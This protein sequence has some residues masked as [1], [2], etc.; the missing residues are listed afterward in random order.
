M[1]RRRL[2]TA[3]EAL[4]R[5]RGGERDAGS[6]SWTR[7][8]TAG[9]TAPSCRRERSPGSPPTSPSDPHLRSGVVPSSGPAV[10]LR[11]AAEI[12]R[13]LERGGRARR[14]TLPRPGE[15]AELLAHVR[16]PL[17][18][19]QTEGRIRILSPYRLRATRAA[20]PVRRRARRRQLPGARRRRPAA[21]RRAP[22][23][24]RARPRAATPPR[25]SATSSTPASRARAS[26]LHL[27]YPAS[28][29]SGTPIPRS[30]FVDE[31]RGLLAP[32][33]T[34]DP[35][36]D[37]LEA[38]I[39]TRAGPED[40][41]PAPGDATTPRELARALAAL[42]G[43]AAESQP[44]PRA[45]RRGRP[46]GARRRSPRPATRC[47]AAARARPARHPDV[48]AALG[49]ASVPTAPRRSRSTT[50]APTAGSSATSSRPRPLG[51]DPEP[52]EDGGLVHEVLE[53]LYREPPTGE[54][55]P[56]PETTSSAGS[57]P[58]RELV[59]EVAAE[60]ALGPRQRATARI[61]IARFDAVLAR[62]LR[63]DAATGGPLRPDPELLEASFG[64]GARRRP[65]AGGARRLL[66]A[67]AD[68]PD[69]RRSSDGQALIRDYKLSSK[70]IAGKK[71]IEEGKLQ[72]PLYL[73]AARGFGLD[74]IGG[75]Y[76]PLGATREDR[77]RGLIDKDHKG[78]L[79][80][81]ETEHHYG[82]DFL[83][84]EEFDEILEAAEQR[85]GEIVAGMRAGAIARDPRG[86]ECPKLVRAGADLPDRARRADRGSRGRGGRGGVSE[87]RAAQP[88]RVRGR[89][90]GRRRAA[91]VPEPR[92]SPRARR[93]RIRRPPSRRR[94][95]TRATAT[96]SS[97]RAPAPARRAC[98]SRA[99]ATR[100]TST[101]SSPERILAFTFTERAAAEMR[102]R[103][104]VELARRAGRAATTPSG[105]PRLHRRRAGRRGR[106]RSRRSTAS[107]GACSPPIPIAAG[108][109]PRF[110]VLDAEE[111]SRLA[112]EAYEAALR[113]LAADRRRRRH[114][115]PPATAGGSPGSIRAAHSD[116]RNRG[117]GRPELPPIQI[118]ALERGGKARAGSAGGASTDAGRRLRR[119]P[120]AARRLRRPLRGALRRALGRRL[121]PPPAARA[122]AAAASA[123]RSPRRS[124]S[125]STTC[126]STSSRTRA[127]SRSSS[128]ARSRGPATRLFAVGDEF[129]SIY[130]FRGADLASF[131]RER[132]RIARARREAPGEAVVLPLS[133]S[134]RSDP[135]VVAAVNAVGAAL[136]DDFRPLRVGQLRPT[137]RRRARPA[138]PVVE[139]AA[140][141]AR[142][143]ERGRAPDPDRAPRRA[144][145]PGRRGALPR[146][147]GCASWP[148]RG[149]TP[150][151]WSCCCAPSPTSTST[152][153]R[154]SSPG[155]DPHVVGGRGYWS[156]QQVADALSLLACVA[157]PLDD[158]S[159][160]GAL[161]SPACAASPDALWMLRRVAGRGRHLWP[162]LGGARPPPARPD[163]P[164]GRARRGARSSAARPPHLGAAD[165][166][167]RRAS[168]CGASASACASCASDAALAAA[169]HAGRADAGDVRLRPRHAAR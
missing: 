156:A 107:A 4:E 15:L 111:A 27:S 22:R 168:A 13:A 60:R 50:P 86:G 47:A 152:P 18:R 103:V 68:R 142:G 75:L 135:D 58:P 167:G 95:S 84:P 93:A 1:L 42:G 5:W 11:A 64:D 114:A 70:V 32:P 118:A 72:M 62:F 38:S 12:E 136:L 161:A 69:R 74:P 105:A 31:V 24:A 137:S 55:R 115:P 14:R 162:A 88:R 91:P 45:P 96:S 98:S 19:G 130:A 149:S 153:R 151:G 147:S 164:R 9:P 131:R 83:E 85:G 53:R 81:G 102:R 138:S 117:A 150:A 127:R 159:L 165:P 129:Q 54:P 37:Q 140:D 97:R 99:T 119:A 133:G 82:T 145:E 25:R 28:D 2:E 36:E 160:L 3:A 16:V 77:P 87:R 157:N 61:R 109:D 80:P 108:L 166:R 106:P 134:F 104:R 123:A 46:R 57:R 44:R 128:S 6:G 90:R 10:E 120:H 52:L 116:L 59:R 39:A 65:P 71:L 146:R 125:A 89:R 132:E 110:R 112:G 158:E 113:D 143:L 35:A 30:P 126:S 141:P 155:L 124:A 144:P 8:A 100:S 43:R 169:R 148:T 94:R 17:W 101:G 33:P 163:G 79:I 139:L 154:S 29:E 56:T 63:R 20:P 41:V 122:R 7:S 67:R 34:T 49:R 73:L 51:P 21:R 66:A 48:L 92:P 26:S 78:A 40:V 121:R 23:R 76:S